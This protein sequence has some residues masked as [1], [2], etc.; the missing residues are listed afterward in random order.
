MNVVEKMVNREIN[1]Q[2][3]RFR[4]LDKHG[5]VQIMY[6]A[7]NAAGKVIVEPELSTLISRC[8]DVLV[9]R[10]H[11]IVSKLEDG[12]QSKVIVI[13]PSDLNQKFLGKLK[14][15]KGK[16]I[17]SDEKKRQERLEVDKRRQEEDDKRNHA[18]RMKRASASVE[19]GIKGSRS[20]KQ[21]EKI[22]KQMNERER[23]HVPDPARGKKSRET[24]V[25]GLKAIKPNNSYEALRSQE[26]K[27]QKPVQ[28]EVE[29]F[30]R[31]MKVMPELRRQEEAR[32]AREKKINEKIAK[33]TEILLKKA[34]SSKN[35]S[36]PIWYRVSNLKT[37]DPKLR[38]MKKEAI[39]NQ[40][41]LIEK[42]L[43]SEKDPDAGLRRSFK[44][45]YLGTK[46]TPTDPESRAA[47]K[48]E[49]IEAEKAKKSL[50]RQKRLV[51]Q[52][53]A[54]ANKI[55][56]ASEIKKKKFSVSERNKKHRERME[57][58]VSP[59]SKYQYKGFKKPMTKAEQRAET[60]RMIAAH[61]RK[62]QKDTY[63]LVLRKRR[64]RRI[65]AA[66]SR[67]HRDMYYIYQ[68]SP[69]RHCDLFPAVLI[70]LAIK[71]IPIVKMAILSKVGGMI[72]QR[73]INHCMRVIQSKGDGT[74]IEA[75]GSLI[76][77]D[78]LALM[79]QLKKE[80]SFIYGK[81]QPIASK[82]LALK[83]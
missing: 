51:A 75:L 53:R 54:V 60:E 44:H 81:I 46:K 73:L 69:R 58:Y 40:R 42:K 32:A 64:G 52:S 1:R 25:L 21:G 56:N 5:D 11:L 36:D 13:K 19:R 28:M 83:G 38:Q 7:M 33:E 9:K 62:N 26:R 23:L 41:R 61:K 30:E 27:R 72:A 55:K 35:P 79:T 8:L 71:L 82:I 57:R 59:E 15:L 63:A 29:R 6:K 4:H 20:G 43:L 68:S 14:A 17:G 3:G 48:I 70:G 74:V 37:L 50:E 39:E 18:E 66:L 47:R 16:L 76:K 34:I 31:E 24:T 49:K 65:D 45:A 67:A 10:P 2:I 12:K 78:L 77:S 80:G 22:L